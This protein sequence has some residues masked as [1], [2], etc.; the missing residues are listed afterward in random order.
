MAGLSQEELAK[1]LL[2]SRQT[3]S[4][5]ENGQTL[6]T[7]DNLIRLKEIFGVSLDEMLSEECT[8]APNTDKELFDEIYSSE[9]VDISNI[10]R[11]FLCPRY[12]ICGLL[13]A[14]VSALITYTVLKNPVGLL[15]IFLPILI[16]VVLA[17]LTLNVA[18]AITTYRQL[19]AI[20]C[21][22]D[23]IK[24]TV[25]INPEAVVI[26]TKINEKTVS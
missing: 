22:A 23:K 10:R 14:L 12:A 2:V 8:D 13:I 24:S 6:P 5:W 15:G 11:A 1:S 25:R 20:K 7:I 26:E 18:S 3:I 17:P 19:R 21:D 4:L 9:A 16:V